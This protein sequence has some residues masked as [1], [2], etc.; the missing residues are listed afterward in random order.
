RR[1]CLVGDGE[2]LCSGEPRAVGAVYNFGQCRRMKLKIRP[3]LFLNRPTAGTNFGTDWSQKEFL[4][5]PILPASKTIWLSRMESVTSS[6]TT[7][8]GCSAT[9]RKFHTVTQTILYAV[10]MPPL[11]PNISPNSPH[12]LR[13]L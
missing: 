11:K 3:S 13:C 1:R 10:R 5:C 12:I 2:G 7:K 9:F 6:R 4:L 8:R